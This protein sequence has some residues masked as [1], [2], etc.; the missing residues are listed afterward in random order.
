MTRRLIPLRIMYTKYNESRYN[1]KATCESSSH[2]I[3]GVSRRSTVA[4]ESHARL[5]FIQKGA[6][7]PSRDLPYITDK[8]S[9]GNTL[10]G[11]QSS[12]QR[13]PSSSNSVSCRGKRSDSLENEVVSH[14]KPVEK[15]SYN[16]STSALNTD[17]K[18][19]RNSSD[20]GYNSSGKIGVDTPTEKRYINSIYP[21]G[22]QRVESKACDY[23]KFSRKTSY[24]RDHPPLPSDNCESLYKHPT[25]S[26]RRTSLDC[27]PSKPG[28]YVNDSRL[29]SVKSVGTAF[30]C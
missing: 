19:R 26:S 12:I 16:S 14:E 22:L 15:S 1:N 2:T 21:D 29:T 4:S 13:I 11:G 3:P 20:S 6:V 8:K 10:K 24:T 25:R 28:S 23:S 27:D 30:Y 18:L 9:M 5:S 7:L 17:V